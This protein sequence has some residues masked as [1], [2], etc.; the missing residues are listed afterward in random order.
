[1]TQNLFGVVVF[2]KGNSSEHQ[3]NFMPIDVCCKL[4][5][6]HVR[7]QIVCYWKHR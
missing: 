1:M 3:T 6:W 4:I 5:F 2:E 7:Y